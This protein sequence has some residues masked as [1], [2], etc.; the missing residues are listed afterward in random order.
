[1]DISFPSDA[2]Y[3]YKSFLYWGNKPNESQS[4]KCEFISRLLGAILELQTNKPFV[5]KPTTNVLER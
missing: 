2:F 5:V 1:M 4:G 3:K